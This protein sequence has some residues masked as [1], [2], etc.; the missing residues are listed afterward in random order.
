MSKSPFQIIPVIDLLDG[1]V[2][3]AVGGLR[4]YYQPIQ[5]MLHATSEPISM[6]R[7]IRAA[8]GLPTLYFAD[9]DAIAGAPPRLDIYRPLIASRFHLWVDAGVSDPATVAPLLEL[10]PAFTNIIAGLETLRGPRELAKIVQMAGVHRVVF[11]LDLFERLP[12][13]AA[14]EAWGTVDSFELAQLAI[15]CG[16]HHL[17]ILDL[18]R[19]GTGRGLGSLDLINRIRDARPSVQ[20]TAGGGISRFE[21]VL[22]LRDAGASGVLIGSALHDGRIG[23]R[24]IERIETH[25]P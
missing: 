21:E 4:T 8:L 19:V 14:A 18:A 20:L 15:D 25:G 24:E 2:V 13:M 7:A 12:R 5:S 9:L 11:S 3:H 17:L 6:A 16:V 22:E 10:D 1:Q 23:I